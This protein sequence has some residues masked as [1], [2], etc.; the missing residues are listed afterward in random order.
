MWAGHTARQVVGVRQVEPEQIA[1]ADQAKRGHVMR[2]GQVE[3]GNVGTAGQVKQGKVG[4]GVTSS[5]ARK[6]DGWEVMYSRD[7][8]QML[9]R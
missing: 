4:K 5:R 8:R 3:Q 6:S 1:G 2:A 7:R 9:V